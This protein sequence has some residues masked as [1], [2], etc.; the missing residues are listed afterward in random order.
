MIPEFGL[1]SV[2]FVKSITNFKE[3]RDAEKIYPS[4]RVLQTIKWRE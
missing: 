3:S 4:N 2:R 1:I